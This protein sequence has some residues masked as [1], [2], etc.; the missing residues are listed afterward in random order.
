MD[1]AETR[2]LAE[3]AGLARLDDRYLAQ[4]AHSVAS[5]RELSGALPKDLHWSEE[6]APTIRLRRRARP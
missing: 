3:A 5:G 1:E 4:L 2:R 6:I